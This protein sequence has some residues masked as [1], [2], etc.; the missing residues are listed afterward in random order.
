MGVN[1]PGMGLASPDRPKLI[2]GLN[3]RRLL[4]ITAGTVGSLLLPPRPVQAIFTPEHKKSFDLP[5]NMGRGIIQADHLETRGAVELLFNPN[6]LQGEVNM[7]LFSYLHNM[8][9]VRVELRGIEPKYILAMQV[10]TPAIFFI[11]SDSFERA[12]TFD[13]TADGHF[14]GA[15]FHKIGGKN[16]EFFMWSRDLQTFG[17]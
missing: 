7:N 6:A 17:L 2:S 1:Y 15:S 16:W 3:R 14:L 11:P 5:D 12:V 13:N 4:G 10:C 8:V 9:G